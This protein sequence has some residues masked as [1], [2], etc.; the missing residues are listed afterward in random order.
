MNKD[1]ITLSYKQLGAIALIV[2]NIILVGPGSWILKELWSQAKSFKTDTE[3]R[4]D[5]LDDELDK[6][7]VKISSN[8]VTRSSFSQYK[9]QMGETIRHLDSKITP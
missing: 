3:K 6:L 5:D 9:E 8:Y 1:S 4:L 7:N 2:V